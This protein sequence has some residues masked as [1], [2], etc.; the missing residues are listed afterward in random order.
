MTKQFMEGNV[1]MAEA[2][3]AAGCRFFVGF[4]ITPQSSIPE[5]LSSRL[6]QVG[7]TY[8]QAE[9]ETVSANILLGASI[10]GARA[11]TATSGPGF[12]LM[13]EGMS[14]MTAAQAPAV[15][16]DVARPGPGL[17]GI[18]GSDEDY[19]YATKAPGAGG[20]RAFVIAPGNLQEAVDFVYQAFDIADKY[21]SLVIVLTDKMI[22]ATKEAVELPALRDLSTLPD[23][24]SWVITKRDNLDPASRRMFPLKRPDGVPFGPALEMFN[25]QMAEKY[26]VWERDEMRWEEYQLEDAEFV[27]FAYGSVSRICRAAVKQLRREGYKVGMFRPITLF[28]FPV[29]QIAA[30]DYRRIKKALCVEMAVPGQ[31]ADDVE[32]ALPHTMALEQYGRSGGCIVMPS[33]VVAKVKELY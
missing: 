11:M 14:F 26:K 7:G 21:R 27:I 19:H 1:A 2:A 28:P 23:K 17:G 30:L 5:Y 9:S 18:D 16:I 32:R 3:V 8:L 20:G 6:P 31:M 12:S 15:I 24:S 4:P 33:E 25:K 22:G 13:A 10:A 29:R